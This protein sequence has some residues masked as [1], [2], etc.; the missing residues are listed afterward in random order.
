MD[1]AA[2]PSVLVLVYRTKQLSPVEITPES[3]DPYLGS[4]PPYSPTKPMEY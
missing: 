1:S 4:T 2:L 3:G